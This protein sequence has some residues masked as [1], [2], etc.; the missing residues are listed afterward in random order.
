MCAENAKSK[1][2]K[3]LDSFVDFGPDASLYDIGMAAPS[4]QEAQRRIRNIVKQMEE[5]NRRIDNLLNSR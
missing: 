2:N 3:T 4:E 1:L 5:L